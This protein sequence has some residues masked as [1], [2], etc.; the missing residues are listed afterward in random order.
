M[1]YNFN[2][3]KGESEMDASKIK[4]FVLTHK[5]KG[6]ETTTRFDAKEFALFKEWVESCKKSGFDYQAYVIEDDGSLEPIR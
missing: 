4:G 2:K 6:R 5:V 1:I 3:G